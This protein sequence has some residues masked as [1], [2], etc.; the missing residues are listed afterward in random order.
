MKSLPKTKTYGVISLLAIFISLYEKR[1]NSQ[2]NHKLK[3]KIE[4]KKAAH[5]IRTDRTITEDDGENEEQGYDI[6]M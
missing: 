4:K 2:I 1:L 3:S 6:I 5:G